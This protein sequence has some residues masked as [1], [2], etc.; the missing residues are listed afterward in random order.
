ML[1]K[2]KYS[3]FDSTLNSSIVTYG[4]LLCK[5]TGRILFSRYI[6]RVRI[7]SKFSTMHVLPIDSRRGL[8]H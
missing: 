8:V 7:S 2:A 5:L 3:A 1:D 6:Y 4:I